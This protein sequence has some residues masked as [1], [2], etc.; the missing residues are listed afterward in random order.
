MRVLFFFP[1]IADTRLQL[2]SKNEMANAFCKQGNHMTIHVGYKNEKAEL[3]GFSKVVY[4]KVDNLFNKFWLYYKTFISAIKDDYDVVL[5]PDR[6]AFFLPFLHFFYLLLKKKTIL[7]SDVRTIPVDVPEG[8]RKFLV[9]GRFNF[10]IRLIDRFSDGLTVITPATLVYI[11]PNLSRLKDKVGIWTSGVDLDVFQKD[12]NDYRRELNLIGKKVLVYHGVLSPNRGIQNLLLALKL[13]N[14]NLDEYVLLLLGEGDAKKELMDISI[15]ANISQSV[16]FLDPVKYYE[17]PKYLRTA[18]CGVLPF[19]DIV[20]W[21]V[22][23]PLKL[24]EYLAL[25]LKIVATDIEAHNFVNTIFKDIEIT[26]G[27]DPLILAQAISRVFVKS[28]PKYNKNLIE[29][30]IS[31]NAQAISLINYI[32]SIELK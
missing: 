31:W 19:P 13:L 29:S 9:E 1:L 18:D 32:K 28:R 30:N 4:F 26:K 27:N 22:S 12:G 15:E 8:L 25:N 3:N 6:M 11:M 24:M 7:V 16:I 2:T 17:V 21:R 20:G 5:I 23:S 14:E 10:S